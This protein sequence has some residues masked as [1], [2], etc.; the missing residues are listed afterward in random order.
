MTGCDTSACG[1]QDRPTLITTSRTPNARPR[2]RA[3]WLR[4]G[5]RAHLVSGARVGAVGR[6]LRAT[7]VGAG[8]VALVGLTAWV[9]ASVSVWSVLVYLALMVLIFVTPPGRRPRATA[10]EVIAESHGAGLSRGVRV[11]CVD[12]VDQHHSVAEPVSGS[13][14]TEL[15]EPPGSSP[16]SV[17]SSTAK[18]RQGRIRARKVTRTAAGPVPDTVRVAWIQVGPGKFVRVEGG[19]QAFDQ[20]QTEEVA[21]GPA[22]ATPVYAPL[23]STAPAEVLAAQDLPTPQETISGDEGMVTVSGDSVLGS[24][25]EGIGIAPSAFSPSPPITVLV[26]GLVHDVS[27]VGADPEADPG[28]MAKLGGQMPGRGAEPGRFWS[29]WRTSRGRR[30]LLWSGLASTTLRRNRAS[31]RREVRHGLQRRRLLWARFTPNA[32]RQQAAIRAF[33]RVAHVE[34]GAATS[35]AA[36]SPRREWRDGSCRPEPAVG[37]LTDI[38]GRWDRLVDVLFAQRDQSFLYAR[39][40]T[41]SKYWKPVS[42]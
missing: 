14:T 19:I 18:P 26:K 33:G 3:R 9:V 34:R 23:T 35:V 13:V 28:S 38:P 20:V 11:D 39:L 15:T 31:S 24:V 2:P 40:L 27:G 22:V 6:R 7:G 1:R 29:A 37:L 30:G 5:V 32:R 10:S 16:D 12:G 17:G 36:L 4:V 41:A 25:T 21:A 42:E 8:L